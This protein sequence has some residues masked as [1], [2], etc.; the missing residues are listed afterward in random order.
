MGDVRLQGVEEG[1]KSV[2]ANLVQ[3]YRYDMSVPAGYDLTEHGTFTYRFLDHYFTEPDR[4]VDFI[5]VDAA[6]AGFVMSRLL[7]D[8]RREMSEFFVLRRHRR[9]GVGR[10]AAQLTFARFPGP[11]EVFCM[12]TNVEG[13]AFWPAVIEAAAGEEVAGERVQSPVARWAGV[14]FRFDAR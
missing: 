5:R 3:L 2:V 14:R 6:M 13:Q 9:R 4:S 1:D 7:D 8:G 12:D 11:W 10:T